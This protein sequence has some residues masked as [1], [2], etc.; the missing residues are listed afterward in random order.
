MI[1][2]PKPKGV[3]VFYHKIFTKSGINRHLQKH[4]ESE[5]I[6]GKPGLSYLLKIEMDPSW[7]RAP[8]FLSLWMDGEAIMDDLDTFLRNIWL[9]CCGHM[10]SFTDPKKRRRS[11][12]FGFFDVQELLDQGKTK[13]YEDYMEDHKGEIPMSKK[14]KN[15]FSKGL[16]LMYEYDFGSTTKLEIVVIGAYKVKAPEAIVLLSRNEPLALSCTS[17][18]KEPANQTCTQCSYE[19]EA[20]FCEK[21]AEEHSESCADFEEYASIP[22][23]NSPRIGVCGYEGGRIDLERDVL[24]TL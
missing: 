21:C 22:I 8:Y 19:E 15:V 7:G 2:S 6:Q 18:A 20:M 3:C 9:E 1:E 12:G 11:M 14:T 5:M 16:K 10:S 13:E 23:V 4:L 17:C 24:K